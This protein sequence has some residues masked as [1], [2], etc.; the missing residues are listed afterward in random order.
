MQHKNLN[1]HF[2]P[3]KMLPHTPKGC[4]HPWLETPALEYICSVFHQEVLVLRYCALVFNRNQLSPS[5][6]VA[7]KIEYPSDAISRLNFL[8]LR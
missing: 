5:C 8:K 7:V 3:P 2:T 1:D 4:E 6:K